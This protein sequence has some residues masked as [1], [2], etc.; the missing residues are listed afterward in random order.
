[1]WKKRIKKLF[2]EKIDLSTFSIW[3]IENYPKSVNFIKKNPDYQY[4]FKYE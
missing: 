2:K 3:L 1:M 4:N